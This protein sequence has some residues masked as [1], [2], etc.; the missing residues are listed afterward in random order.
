VLLHRHGRLSVVNR[1]KIERVRL[2]RR[3]LSSSGERI[4]WWCLLVRLSLIVKLAEEQILLLRGL[5]L[6]LLACG[7]RGC[8]N[9]I[10]VDH[11]LIRLLAGSVAYHR[12]KIDLLALLRSGGPSSVERVEVKVSDLTRVAA[13]KVE[14]IW[15]CLAI[16]PASAQLVQNRAIKVVFFVSVV[17][18]VVFVGGFRL[19]YLLLQRFAFVFD[20]LGV[21]GLA[22][23]LERLE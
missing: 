19:G 6:S 22:Q 17:F 9:I 15:L 21:L 5:G 14:H 12:Y 16:S 1:V 18:V 2:C 3:L 11:W 13:Q 7:W 8:E 4:D 23:D 10:E 20:E